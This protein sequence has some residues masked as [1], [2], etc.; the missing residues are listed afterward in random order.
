MSCPLPLND[1]TIDKAALLLHIADNC[2][3]TC[4]HAI[5]AVTGNKSIAILQSDLSTILAKKSHF[6]AT[7]K[8]MDLLERSFYTWNLTK[9]LPSKQIDHLTKH[10]NFRTRKLVDVMRLLG[11]SRENTSASTAKYKQIERYVKKREEE[12]LKLTSNPPSSL[13]IEI[14]DTSVEETVSP[15]YSSATSGTST[16]FTFDQSSNGS[17]DASTNTSNSTSKLA[18][19]PN[20]NASIQSEYSKLTTGPNIR[21]TSKQMQDSRIDEASWN[22]LH[23]TAYKTGSILYQAKQNKDCKLEHLSSA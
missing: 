19:K 22:R 13:V 6:D 16:A 3:L 21:K 20:K 11:C 8:P 9:Q 17:P 2:H 7:R 1:E 5:L 15:L 23:S 14:N 4:D 12:S 18:P 10:K